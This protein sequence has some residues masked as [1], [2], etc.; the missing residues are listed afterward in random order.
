MDKTRSFSLSEFPIKIAAIVLMTLDHIGVFLLSYIAKGSLSSDLTTLADVF[1]IIGRLAYP[2]FAFMLIEGMR[3]TKSQPKYILRIAALL[4]VMLVVEAIFIYGFNL[5]ALQMNPWMDLFLGAATTYFLD[6][7]KKEGKK[8][9]L[10]L[11][12]L[13]PLAYS[14]LSFG[15]RLY[16]A[17]NPLTTVIWLPSFLRADYS[18]LG[19]FMVLGYYFSYYVTDAFSKKNCK[20]MGVPFEAYKD[21]EDYQKTANLFASASLVI[22]IVLFWGLSFIGYNPNTGTKPYD[23][24]NMGLEAYCLIDLASLYL[25]N[26]KRGYNSKIFQYG[27]Y[28]YF[29]LHIALLFLIFALKFGL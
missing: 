10:A 18:L 22:V 28:L 6:H 14:G 8:R 27:S 11:L 15:L 9:W 13:L 19:S 2:L 25:Y 24:Y 12:A 16:E 3:H 5:G 7:L 26:G 17:A 1:R 4:V 29:P 23:V 20:I 21:T